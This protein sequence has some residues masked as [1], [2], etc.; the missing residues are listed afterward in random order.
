MNQQEELKLQI[1]TYRNFIIEADQKQQESFDKTVLTL[2]GGALGI[3][4][5]FLKD[6]VGTNPIHPVLITLAWIFWGV[7]VSCTLI[8]FFTSHLTLN[9]IIDHIDQNISAD[10]I[11]KIYENSPEKSFKVLTNILNVTS[12]ALFILG[13][14]LTAIFAFYNF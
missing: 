6:I 13:V 7:S 5:A 9:K 3:T 11:Q 4:F 8:S 2:S 10:S 1:L 12:A 14:I